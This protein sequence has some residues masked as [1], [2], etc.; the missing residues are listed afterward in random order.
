MAKSK[1]KINV[2]GMDFALVTEDDPAYIES[3]AK[4]LSNKIEELVESN[5]N[6]SVAQAAVL[7]ALDC[8]DELSKHNN[9]SDNLRAQIKDYL[10]DAARAR[11]E[12]ENYKR[13]LDKLKAQLR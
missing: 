11:M 3:L 4:Q 6:I 12:A 10:E 8:E 2:A 7:V 5:T 13:E 9:S 1:V